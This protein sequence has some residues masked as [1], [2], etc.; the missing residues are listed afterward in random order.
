[1]GKKQARTTKPSRVVRTDY[2]IMKRYHLTIGQKI[3]NK[4]LRH[5]WIIPNEGRQGREKKSKKVNRW[6]LKTNGALL[7]WG[8]LLCWKTATRRDPWEI[9]E[10]PYSRKKFGY[11]FFFFFFSFSIFFFYNF[12][13]IFFLYAYVFIFS[14]F[15]LFTL[16]FFLFS[17]SFTLNLKLEVVFFST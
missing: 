5:Y 6:A 4:T 1:M 10:S 8:T 12:F 2:Q 15:F 14:F 13:F 9:G 17:F 7:L 11:Y 16:F 3:P